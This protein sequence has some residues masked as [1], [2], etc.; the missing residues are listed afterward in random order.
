MLIGA[1]SGAAL[2]TGVLALVTD[3]S[4]GGEATA[5]KPARWQMATHPMNGGGAM[6]LK[7]SF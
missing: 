4:G 6:S 3:W 7:G 5:K 1:A 2:I